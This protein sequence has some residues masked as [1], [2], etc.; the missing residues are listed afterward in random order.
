MLEGSS[1]VVLGILVVVSK[2]VVVCMVV[3]CV[4]V[5]CV[6]VMVIVVV[7]IRV[8]LLGMF[9]NL[10][11]LHTRAQHLWFLGML[12]IVRCAT[13]VANQDISG[14]IATNSG[15]ILKVAEGVE[16][17][18]MAAEMVEETRVFRAN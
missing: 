1:V 10:G 18:G 3:E 2:G 7:V 12:Q 16:M 13:T 8:L 4:V 11:I 9:R 15:M 14:R 17:A 6:V 5:M